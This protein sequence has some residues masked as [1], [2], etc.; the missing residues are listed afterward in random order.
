MYF[1][2]IDGGGTKTKF[3]IVDENLNIIGS[4]IKGTSHYNQIGFDNVGILLKE[5]IDEVCEINNVS[6]D[7][8]GNVFIGIAGYG[9]IKD[10]VNNIEK[11]IKNALG[12]LRYNIGNDVEIA[13]TGS[14]NGKYG[15]NII[16]G[17]GSIALA[18]DKEGN[19][20]RC[21]GWGYRLG[22]EGSAYY[23]GME[24]LRCFTMQSDGRLNKTLLYN[25]I[26]EKLNINNDYDIIK[27]INEEIN[28][29][30]TEIA[31]LSKI[32][33]EAAKKGDK[34]AIEIFD[35]AAFELSKNINTLGIHFDENETVIVSYS[36]GV[37][38]S[39]EL[40]L[41]PLEKYLNNKRFKIVEPI[42][43]PDMG[44]CILAKRRYTK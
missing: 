14:L 41:K 43:P 33:Y 30:R 26:K 35:K 9:K 36:G 10:I 40:I 34:C 23:I 5:G 29:D 17:T 2:G 28:G 20:H 27:Y 21:G 24:T 19:L 18:L 31:D 25:D 8:I 12:D 4:I 3:T 16:A 22:D 44:A 13:L 7:E 32:C 11:S 39:G 15:I 6:L 42:A 37:F 38:K 1:L